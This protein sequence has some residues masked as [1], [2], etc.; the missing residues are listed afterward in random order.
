VFSLRDFPL[1]A[2]SFGSLLI[3]ILA[4][5]ACAPLQPYPV[6]CMLLLFLSFPSIRFYALEVPL[7]TWRSWQM[8]SKV[9]SL[10]DRSAPRPR[11]LSEVVKPLP[12]FLA[13]ACSMINVFH[14]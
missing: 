10:S 8:K 2:V 9:A 5:E 14:V 4:P 11:P 13:L 12:C 7:R 1:L 3:G 6:V